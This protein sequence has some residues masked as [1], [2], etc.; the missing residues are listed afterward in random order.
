MKENLS[1]M[2]L[3]EARNTGVSR[4]LV[5]EILRYAIH[6]GPGIRTL[7]FLKGCPLRCLWC[8]NPETQKTFTEI[9]YF[10]EKCIGC[11]RCIQLCPYHA[12]SRTGAGELATDWVACA[13]NCYLG[14]A[15]AFSCTLKCYSRARKVI[16]DFMTVEEVM[17]EVEKD[18]ALYVRTGGGITI[19]GGEPLSQPD[20]LL[21]LLTKCRDRGIQTAIETCGH[22]PWGNFE[23]VIDFLDDIFFDIKAI[24]AELHRRLTGLSNEMILQN[25]EKLEALLPSKRYHLILRVP[26]VPGYNDSKEN[27]RQIFDYICRQLPSIKEIELLGYHR[28]GRGKYETIGQQY[29]LREV[30]P[31][32]QQQMVELEKMAA[33]YGLQPHRE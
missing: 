28:L 13:R 6:D 2:P 23:N 32:D 16:G 18:H 15:S 12:V 22:A 7:V 27:L 9:A 1:A 30:K 21:D 10:K 3:L 24:D 25:I 29:D 31:P 5:S 19:S 4:G 14:N 33:R 20:F 17:K 26:I 11:D 8:S